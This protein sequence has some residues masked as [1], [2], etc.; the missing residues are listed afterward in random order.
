[1]RERGGFQMER[2]KLQKGRHPRT[3]S[4]GVQKGTGP[5]D[6]FQIKS[7]GGLPDVRMSGFI[8]ERVARGRIVLKGVANY[9]DSG[10][11]RSFILHLQNN[12]K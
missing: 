5:A 1:M 3:A 7:Q 12:L 6:E 10:V 4:R 8:R 2:L 9:S 11:S